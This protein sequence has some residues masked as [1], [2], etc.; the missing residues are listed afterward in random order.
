MHPAE[1]QGSSM[2]LGPQWELQEL[3]LLPTAATPRSN[4]L[5]PG[6]NLFSAGAGGVSFGATMK[7][8]QQ[9]SSSP[10]LRTL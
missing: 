10:E 3:P 4:T 5:A 2:Q 7:C 6:I 1:G 9:L 8:F